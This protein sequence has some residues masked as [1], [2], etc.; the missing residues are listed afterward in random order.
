[1]YLFAD[2]VNVLKM[3]KKVCIHTSN[4]NQFHLTA[5]IIFPMV[6]ETKT[7]VAIEGLFKEDAFALYFRK[8]HGKVS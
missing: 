4:T 7:R 5:T 1:M 8:K 3:F 2:E 6:E